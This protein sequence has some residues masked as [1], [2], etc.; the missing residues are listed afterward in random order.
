MAAKVIMEKIGAGA[1]VV[2]VR[3]AEEFNDGNFAG[4]VNIPLQDLQRR[5]GEIPKDKPVILYCAS[6][7]RSSVGAR[8]LKQSGYADVI[9][10]GGLDDL[11]G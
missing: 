1:T 11:A 8:F 10:A 9:N 3:T 6:G 7:A 4:A 2:D 5:V